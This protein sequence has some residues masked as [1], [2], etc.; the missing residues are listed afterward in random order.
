MAA[1]KGTRPPAAGKG[2]KPGS[3]NK[4]PREA[5]QAFAHAFEECGGVRG[6][7]AWGRE[8]QTEFYKLYARLIQVEVGGIGGGP[9]Q[10]VVELKFVEK[11]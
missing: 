8:N 10:S 6:L 5:K 2:R 1:P 9:I 7:V 11:A 4:I 3:K